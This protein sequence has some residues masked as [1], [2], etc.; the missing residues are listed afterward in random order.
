MKRAREGVAVLAA[1]VMC[2]LAAPRA[3]PR[4]GRC[5]TT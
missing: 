1:V 5:H 2:A 4:A 3:S